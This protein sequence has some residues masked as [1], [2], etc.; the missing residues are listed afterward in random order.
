MLNWTRTN[1]NRQDARVA[2][3][4]DRYAVSRSRIGGRWTAHHDGQPISYIAGVVDTYWS[5]SEAKLACERD[6]NWRSRK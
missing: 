4:P 3:Q 6:A 5:V 2:G 1:D